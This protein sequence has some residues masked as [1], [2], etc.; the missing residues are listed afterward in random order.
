MNGE[1]CCI[2]GVCCPSGSESQVTAMVNEFAHD[3]PE[4][5][6]DQ[7]QAVARWV[8]KNFDLAPAGS[9]NV[10]KTKLAEHIKKAQK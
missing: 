6:R 4:V 1:V 3:H 5:D 2:L 10:F 7:V 9:L 8:L